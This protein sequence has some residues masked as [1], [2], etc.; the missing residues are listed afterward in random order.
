[1]YKRCL[2]LLNLMCTVRYTKFRYPGM[3]LLQ[4]VLSVNNNTVLGRIVNRRVN[5]SLWFGQTIQIPIG[6]ILQVAQMSLSSIPSCSIL[7]L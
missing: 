1:M 6:D 7:V 4:R 3:P 5:P 2:R